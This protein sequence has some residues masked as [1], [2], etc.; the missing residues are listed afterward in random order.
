MA[1]HDHEPDWEEL[2]QGW[3]EEGNHD[4]LGLTGSGRGARQSPFYLRLS[5]RPA[6]QLG[7]LADK[8]PEPLDAPEVRVAFCARLPAETAVAQPRPARELRSVGAV[9][10]RACIQSAC[11]RSIFRFTGSAGAGEA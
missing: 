1:K 11:G 5:V 4:E 2:K 6:R 8:R 9:G 10:A 7:Q 3:L